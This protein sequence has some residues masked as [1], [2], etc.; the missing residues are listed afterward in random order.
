M[1]PA[2]VQRRTGFVFGLATLLAVV[3]G[4][5]SFAATTN[6]FFTQ[7][8]PGEGYSTASNL[9]G[10]AGWTGEG[11][12]GNGILPNF[13]T[14]QGQQAYIGYDAP[15]PADDRLFLWRPINF[16]PIATGYPL[17]TFS[18]LMNIRDSEL[19]SYRDI[20]RWSVY[21]TQAKR[22]FSIVF[23]NKYADISYQLDGTNDVA[24]T[25]LPFVNG[26]N[27]TLN[28]TMNFAA[29]R[30]SAT[31]NDTLIATNQPITTT[32]A[33]LNLGDVDAVWLVNQ[34]NG[35]NAPGDNYMLFDNYRITAETIPVPAAQMQFLGRTGEGWTLFQV[36]G[37]TGS[38][39]AVEGTT[40][41]VNWTAL[42]TNVV[43][44]ISFDVVDKSAVGLKQRFYR[45][46]LVP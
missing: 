43:D 5:T 7:F 9:V 33:A 31:C 13:I 37:E 15:N 3:A 28:V 30:W 22:L 39:W 27:Y 17:V 42:N 40:N 25:Y 35:T 36:F 23:D 24:L 18:V 46:R 26:S 21:N 12:G 14:G 11:S 2:L 4:G 44:G 34:I 8:E 32:N 6:I 45:A 16:N 19:V 1:K 41:L 29:N 20:F 10:Q 38:R